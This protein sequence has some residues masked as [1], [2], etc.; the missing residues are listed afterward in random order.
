MGTFRH[1]LRPI[2]I[3][4][5]R[6]TP[7][8]PRRI[9]CVDTE[10]TVRVVDGQTGK[11][12]HRFRLGVATATWIR[13]GEAVY[14][15]IVRFNS[16][17]DFWRWL[18]NTTG[19]RG[20]T[21]V[22]AHNLGYDL[23][24]LGFWSIIDAGDMELVAAILEDPP[25]HIITRKGRCI[26]HWC[27]TLNYWRMPLRELGISTGLG[28]SIMPA[29]S[30]PDSEW[31]DYCQRD[32]EIV[33]RA[34]VGLVSHV[35]STQMCSWQATAPSLAWRCF[36]TNFY[37]G[38]IYIHDDEHANKIERAAYYGGRVECHRIG[39]IH[40]TVDVV[41][42]NGL[43][44]SVM[45]SKTYP[46]RFVGSLENINVKSLYTL[47]S[48]KGVV[49]VVRVRTNSHEYPIRLNGSP[50]HRRGTFDTVLAGPE[51]RLAVERGDISHVYTAW[52]YESAD[53]FGAYVSHFFNSRMVSRAAN[54]SAGENLAKLMLNSLH[55][56]FGQRGRRWVP[57]EAGP[58]P[59][60]W[61]CWAEYNAATGQHRK[62]RAVAGLT[63]SL[64]DTGESRH[65]FPAISAHVTSYARV[66]MDRIKR[67][68]GVGNVLYEDTDCIHCVQPGYL[69]LIDTGMIDPAELGKLKLVG[70]YPDAEY[71]GP[72]DYRCGENVVNCCVKSSAVKISDNSF[73]QDRWPGI[74]TVIQSGPN[75]SYRTDEV[76]IKLSRSK[77]AGRIDA[78]GHVLPLFA[79]GEKHDAIGT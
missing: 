66:E 45:R 64:V 35:A 55:G 48:E 75:A 31:Y 40:E 61:G 43:Y 78:N 23:T 41:D 18:Y 28:K 11:R 34:V 33:E 46:V 59:K 22:F 62:C 4:G 37:H 49:A 53:I 1:Q 38:G 13:S 24:M 8:H 29:V 63:Q 26:I 14:R 77:Y 17:D 67:I 25:T 74:A 50:S 42:V 27:D 5:S 36:L 44:P 79:K 7:V 52:N 3:T 76:L 19:R 72:K 58:V 65:S 70:S 51:L 2:K 68:A 12:L 16:R 39:H 69:N 71:W 54:N 21:W 56:K 60:R 32:V 47:A 30:A 57:S 20:A 9:I 6:A 73:R 10:S 15:N